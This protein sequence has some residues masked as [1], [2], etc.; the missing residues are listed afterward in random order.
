[1]RAQMTAKKKWAKMGKKMSALCP[2]RTSDLIMFQ[3]LVRY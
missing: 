2:N 3:T 1:L